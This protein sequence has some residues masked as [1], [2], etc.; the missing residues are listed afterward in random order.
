[1]LVA[2]GALLLGGCGSQGSSDD[3]GAEPAA[4][5]PLRKV[6][7]T[8]DGYEGPENVGILM[9]QQRGY[10]AAAGLSVSIHSPAR[11][12]RPVHD[13][14]A[15]QADFGVTQEPQL[16]LAKAKGAPVIGVRCLLHGPTAAMV[17]LKKSQ[18]GGIAGLK[19]KTIAI[20]AVAFQE[21]FLANVL[22]HH[23][24]ALDDVKVEKVGYGLVSALVSGRA[25][26]I[27]GASWNLEGVQLEAQGLK[28]V[29]TRLR[30]IGAPFYD[31]FLAIARTD[32]VAKDPRLM[33]DFASAVGRGTAAAIAN[34]RA[35]A[36]AIEEAGLGGPRLSRKTL[37]AEVAA[38]LPL[39]SKSGYMYPEESL[40]LTDWMR[41]EGMM[42]ESPRP[43]E[44]LNNEFASWRP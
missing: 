12:A 28:P 35:A 43:E 21:A 2:A 18:I 19:G 36:V 39:L 27:F 30:D 9:A 33:Q 13:V 11:P 3:S 24:L 38:T 6:S 40:R 14:I 44:M 26:A 20:P 23:G 8:L 16:A 5:G 25:D 10:F 42:A 4:S 15:H 31:E 22:V 41:D 34:P 7:V 1:M 37:E 29:V 17:W 32:R